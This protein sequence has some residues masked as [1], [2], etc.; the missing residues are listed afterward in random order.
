[1]Q[2]VAVVGAG[3]T[4]LWLAAELRLGGA[5]VTVLE[6][7]VER[8]PN[9]KALTIHPRTLEVLD[10]RGVAEPFL[11]EGIRIPDGHFA[12]LTQRL[13]FSVLDTP[14]P[15][16]L[17]LVQAR[18]EELLEDRA[19]RMGATIRRGCEVTGLAEDGVV[20]ADGE[21]VRARY[22]AGCDG[23]RSTV[24]AAAGIDFPGTGPT[25]WGWLGDVALDAPPERGFANITGPDG[26]LMVVPLPGGLHRIV[27]GDPGA[28]QEAWPGELTLDE[29]R[30]TVT[31][32]AG[33]DFGLRDPVWLSRFSN[34]TRQAVNYRKGNVLLAGD[35]AHM[36][37]PT[38][39]VGMNVGIQDAHNLGWKLAAAATGRADE[40]LLDTYH[41]ERHPV[42]AELLEHTRA[43]T[44]LMTTFSPEGQAL[45][46]VMGGL[47]SKAPDMSREL[48]ER[49]SG[50]GVT[51]A[52]GRRVRNLRMP[53]GST[54]FE[55]LR[56]G[57]HVA[58]GE[59][60]VRPDGH[61]AA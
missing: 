56:T 39:G 60:L 34:A 24:R 13:D 38:G 30:A 61:L 1:M 28:N 45:R 8:D 6:S 11:D 29:L 51:Y 33:T 41:E 18:T 36:H 12:G 59:G 55:R 54:L 5:S 16:T 17:V 15:F 26:G 42:G 47:I 22:V 44:A 25:T 10:S 53:D 37:F 49:L 57:E 27:G 52:T 46:A 43:Q 31:R 35:A 21:V 7:R 48:A 2:D 50:L 20:L 23:T 40:T 14:F 3:P 32:I 9:S 4:G 19:R 58:T